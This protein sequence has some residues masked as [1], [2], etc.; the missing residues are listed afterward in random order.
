MITG[1]ILAGGDGTRL[2]YENANKTTIPFN[3]KPLIQYG[4]DLYHGIADTTVIVVG[5]YP[6]SV[7]AV[8]HDPSVIYAHQAERLGTGHAV[9]VAVAEMERQGLS[10]ET[11]MV[12]YGDHM[13]FYTQD[14]ISRM[15]RKHKEKQAAITLISAEYDDPDMLAWGR[16]IRDDTGNV[17]DIIEQKDAT[18]DQRKMKELNT[19]F[20][21]FEYQFLKQSLPLLEKS[22]HTKEIYLT[23]LIKIANSLN[24]TVV[25]FDVP[26]QYVGIGINTAEQLAQSQKLHALTS[27]VLQ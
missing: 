5:A 23:D 3:G 16:I 18:E 17:K 27:P 21:C 20:Y 9:Q 10:P 25:A 13:M 2:K 4:L 24:R 14:I 11:V 15:L 19:G 8:V 26:F 7:K 6:E 12:G 22:P 1:I